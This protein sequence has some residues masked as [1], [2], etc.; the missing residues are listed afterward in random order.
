M[1]R[2]K[3]LILVMI[4][5][6]VIAGGLKIWQQHRHMDLVLENLTPPVV[7]LIAEAPQVELLKVKLVRETDPPPN[8]ETL[9]IE[10]NQYEIVDRHDVTTAKGLADVRD[11]LVDNA[12]YNAWKVKLEPGPKF[13]QYVLVFTEGQ[14]HARLAFEITDNGVTLVKLLDDGPYFIANPISHGLQTFFAAQFKPAEAP[15]KK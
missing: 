11:R 9:K 14:Q 1:N 7:R 8:G 3:L 4:A 5:A 15:A 13:W 6:G 2:G 10:G 12:S